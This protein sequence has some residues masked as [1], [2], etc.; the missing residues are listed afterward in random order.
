MPFTDNG[1]ERKILEWTK[2]SHGNSR[3]DSV[4]GSKTNDT[5]IKHQA[6]QPIGPQIQ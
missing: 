3:V 6:S 1:S 2:V 4:L 5:T